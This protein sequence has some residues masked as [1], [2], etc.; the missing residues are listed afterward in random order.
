MTTIE[1]LFTKHSVPTYFALTFA[2]SW[3]GVLLVIGGLAV[4]SGVRAQ[5]NPVFPMALLAMVAGPALAG[6]LMTCLAHGFAGLRELVARMLKWQV[7]R[8]WYAIALFA[9]PV[10]TLATCLALIPFSP[11][12]VPSIA[13]A[14]DKMSA[15]LLG[16][17]VALTAGVLEEL[18]WT[19]FALPKMRRRYGVI[20]TGII[21]GL[22]W[23]AWH[24]LVV[25]WGIGNRAGAI[26]LPL[27]VVLDGLT[28]LVAFRVLMVWVYDRTGSL[29]V[30]MLMHV[31]LTACILVLWPSTTGAR[32][33]THDVVFAG[34]VWIVLA[35]LALA[36]TG[37]LTH[38]PARRRIA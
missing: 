12:F 11:E 3:G 24:V 25:V 10:L 5:E 31:S 36:S 1:A 21:L 9:A 20:T 23:S 35:V 4:L 18:G 2:I 15:L 28:A 27:F 26:P 33:I 34:A 22:M 14:D 7:G 19:G 6:I 29:L 8:R 17:A 30:A 38:W 16:L 13:I 32:L 37:Q